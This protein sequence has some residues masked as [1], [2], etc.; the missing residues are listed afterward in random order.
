M[1]NTSLSEPGPL[2]EGVAAFP[3]PL[4]ADARES[5]VFYENIPYA[6]EEGYRPQFL[7]LR[8]PAGT[9]PASPAPLIVWVHG[10]GWVY[11]SR[12]RQAPNLHAHRVVEQA[13]DAGY[14]VALIDYRLAKEAAF[15]AQVLDIRAAIR[16]LRANASDYALDPARMAL[17]GESAGAHLVLMHGLCGSID[18]D[19]NGRV[20]EH[21]DQSEDVQAIVEW[22]GPATLAVPV[23][24]AGP[25]AVSEENGTYTTSPVEILLASSSWS[26]EE[27]SPL[28]HVRADAPPLFIAHGRQDRQV[29]VEQS[30]ALYRAMLDAGAEVEYFETDGDHVFTGADTLPE[31]MSRSL[32]FIGRHLA[33]HGSPQPVSSHTE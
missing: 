28:T 20:G 9:G 32:D 3:C 15:P 14:A 11:G 25:A 26:A 7:D 6:A 33:R 13:L 22:Y 1:S 27:L 31:V 21:F 4:P 5:A 23:A 30:R 19:R 12:R 17:L 16:W 8:V 10:G 24:P 18:G 2:T 29:D